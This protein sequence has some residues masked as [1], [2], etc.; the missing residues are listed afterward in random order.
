MAYERVE[1]I[2]SVERRRRWSTQEKL[3]LV[4]ESYRAEGGV[5]VVADQAGLHRSLLQRWR[6]QV[7]DGTLVADRLG[8]PSFVPLAID[9]S[10]AA[11]TPALTTAVAGVPHGAVRGVVEIDLPNGCRV[12]VE[13][14]IPTAALRRIIGALA[15]R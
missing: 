14:D 10:A 5:G 8:A 12:R 3:R 11:A 15:R 4:A 13:Q 7:R 2:T 1:V 6:R 9:D